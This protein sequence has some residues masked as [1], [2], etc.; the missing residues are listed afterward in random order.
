MRLSRKMLSSRE[1]G[2]TFDFHS[3]FDRFQIV[4]NVEY[5]GRP[6]CL[7]YHYGG[8]YRS[9]YCRHDCRITTAGIVLKQPRR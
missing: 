1:Q 8:F 6:E 2:F 4:K 3:F 5:I 7:D 9:F